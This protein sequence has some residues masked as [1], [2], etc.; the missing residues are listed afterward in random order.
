MGGALHGRK[1]KMN[2]SSRCSDC[3]ACVGRLFSQI[4]V[5]G[6]SRASMWAETVRS[7]ELVVFR[8]RG[9]EGKGQG[10][11]NEQSYR[12]VGS[13][14]P[15]R[16]GIVEGSE[17]DSCVEARNY[18]HLVVMVHGLG[19]AQEDWDVL[20]EKLVGELEE[21]GEDV[22][23]YASKVNRK[24]GTF[25]GIDV[26]SERLAME[27]KVVL[28]MNPGL[29]YISFL[30]HS[31]GGLIA[32]HACGVHYDA[33]SGRIFGLEARHIVTIATPH[34]GCHVE[35]ESQVPMIGWGR[36][37]PLLGANVLKVMFNAAT[38]PSVVGSVG[39]RSLQQLF[40]HDGGDSIGQPLILKLVQDYPGEGWFF[41]AL[42]QF[43]TRVCY[44][45]SSGDA[46]VGW[47]NASLRKVSELPVSLN[48][49]FKGRGIL[50]EDALHQGLWKQEGNAEN[51]S[52]GS[53]KEAPRDAEESSESSG[54]EFDLEEDSDFG[55]K[56]EADSKEDLMMSCESFPT[57]NN[58]FRGSD[59][60]VIVDYMLERL[61]SLPW[62]R[63][64]VSFK[65]K[66]V[67][68]MA[69]TH[70]QVTRK[71][72]DFVGISVAEHIAQ[73]FV[74]LERLVR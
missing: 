54:V 28:K 12:V 70:I 61:Q 47:A 7:S 43:Q 20:K 49:S 64:D 63:I 46:L 53:S 33:Q 44:A 14:S 24:S 62:C 52:N 31:M 22:L 21:E 59:R 74:D 18:E 56:H 38:S 50:M 51:G 32:R 3:V 26:C 17:A 8:S 39:K 29:R 15:V 58:E 5:A 72:M 34:L 45:N 6:S 36:N 67:P 42:K 4:K 69:H 25:A 71:W 41:S 10:R 40:M 37:I 57:Q 55:E 9:G 68:F 30:C 2:V 35:G 48:A 11:W 19:G 27:L 60:Q 16:G 66:S 65:K 23:L 73:R 13:A 1:P